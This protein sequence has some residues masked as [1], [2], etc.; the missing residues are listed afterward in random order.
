MKRI[1]ISISL[2]A[3]I[4]SANAQLET[5]DALQA[6]SQSDYT[7]VERNYDG[8]IKSVMYSPTDN[9]I[10][11]TAYEFFSGTLKK[12]ET[13]NFVLDTSKETDFGMHFERYQQ[14]YQGV[15]VDDGHYNFRFKDGRLKGVKGHYVNVADIN[16]IP[17]I[18]EKEAINLYAFN[19]GIGQ[20]DVINSYVGLMIKEIPNAEGKEPEVILVY[21]V[22]LLTPQNRYGYIGYIDAHTGKLLC[23]EDAFIN[24]S[25]TGLFYTYYNS[26]NNPK[27]GYT[28]NH[29]NKYYLEDHVRGHGI[30]TYTLNQQTGNTEIASDNDNI[31][32]QAEM[33]SYTMALDV[34]WTMENIYDI[35]A[36]LFSHNSYDGNYHNIKSII[37]N[38]NDACYN[39]YADYFF[40]G[41]ASGNSTNGPA[42]SV[43]II[44]HEFG[45]AILHKTTQFHTGQTG[46][47][48]NAIHEGLADIWGIIF[49]KHITPS[50]NYWKTGE[51]TM[52]N[53]ESCMRNFQNPNDA[54]AHTQI[55]NTYNSGAFFS[56]DPHIVGGLLPY[57]FYLLVNGGSGTNGNNNSYQLIPVG[58]DLAESLFKNTML[59]SYYLANCTT[60][61]D[62][63]W[64]FIEAAEDMGN[65]F[66][67]EQVKNS[68]YAV[69]LNSEPV[70]IYL[71]SYAPGSA[72]YNIYG[73]SS[74]TVNWSFTNAGIYPYP[75]LVPNSSNY[76]CTVSTSSNYS[77][78]LIATIYCD[79]TT[80]TY[81]RYIT[82]TAL[83]SSVG[84]D[85][86]VIPL[87]G[88]SYQ[89]SFAEEYENCYIK[90]YEASS[91]QIKTNEKLEHKNYVLDTSSWKRG[92]YI[93]EMIVGNTK[94]IK[95][96]SVNH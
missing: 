44:G 60:F 62:V 32:T 78:Y 85:M 39:D 66:L 82:G 52:I 80:V 94:Y 57:W 87:D 69:G 50:A 14:Y 40:F 76:S 30:L 64:A 83:P 71:Q 34:H 16:P 13:D 74:C 56:S 26:N 12:R 3:L 42:A 19:F 15:L 67:L 11:K 31:W 25:A 81:S 43:D 55:A 23:K 35:M 28:D 1:V 4:L 63:M 93:I 54:T 29:N 91:L 21:K 18:T 33:G 92:V 5:H 2:C 51:Q 58:F 27:S 84:D 37:D 79:G 65:D 59:T 7:I 90:V 38:S 88:T 45:H 72:T 95:K 77:G 70:H 96:I 68:F 8:S 86:Q 9:N 47:I 61:L 6:L 48:R 73:N 20:D 53:G 75:T 24:Y 41:N 17:S 22:F 36:S 10:P 89:L 49:E 46:D